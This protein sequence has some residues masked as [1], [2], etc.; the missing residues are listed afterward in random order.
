MTPLSRRTLLKGLGASLALPALDAML[1]RAAWSAPETLIK[2]RMAF[3]FVPIGAIMEYWTPAKDGADYELSKTLMPLKD[4]QQD[5]LVLSNFVHDKARPHGD[6][7]GD[8]DRD[9]ATFLTGAHARKSQTDIFIGQSVDQYAADRIGKQTRLPSLEL[10][11]EGG[12]QAKRCEYACAYSGHISWRTPTV[13]MAKEAKPRAAFERLFGGKN[14]PAAQAERALTRRSILDFVAQDT[15]RLTAKLGAGDRQKL[16]QYLTSVRE[17]EQRIE[18]IAAAPER[19]APDVPVPEETPKSWGEHMRLMYDLMLLAFQTDS[20]RICTFMLANGGTYRSLE[21]IGIADA[22]HRLS[23]HG[24]DKDK[25][26]KLQKVDQFMVEQF[27]YFLK[28][29]KSTPEGT[30]TLLDHAMIMYGSALSDPDRHNHENLPIVLAG[31]GGGTIKT[32]RHVK[33]NNAFRTKKEVPLSNLLLSMLD[34]MGV[35]A[36]QFGDSNGRAANLDA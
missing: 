18:R 20:T 26:T 2:N 25:L 11:T 19:P 36:D 29:M 1:P 27:A 9:P 8:H 35:N 12:G 21:E 5:I 4:V 22:Y 7:G 17:V 32:G 14:D 6:G 23:H 10:A 34:R 33:Y 24:K 31:R 13:P 30:G 16:D 3:V 15:Q 28:R